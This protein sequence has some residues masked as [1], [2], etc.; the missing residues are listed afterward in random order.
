M[1]DSYDEFYVVPIDYQKF[2]GKQRRT[3]LIK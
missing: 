1:Y 3:Y 2:L